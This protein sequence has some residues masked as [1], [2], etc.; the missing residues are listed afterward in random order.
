M[1]S[2]K[3]GIPGQRIEP[4]ISHQGFMKYMMERYPEI[5]ADEPKFTKKQRDS[6]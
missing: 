6:S 1:K 3:K 4:L 2:H 5:T